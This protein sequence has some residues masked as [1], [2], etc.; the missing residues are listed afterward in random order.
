MLLRRFAWADAEI[1]AGNYAEFRA[2]MVADNLAGLEGLQVGLV[3]FGTIGRA[4]AQ[5]FARM[6]AKRLLLRS[7]AARRLGGSAI[8]AS[9]C[10]STN[11][12]RPPMWC[13][14]TCRCCRRRRA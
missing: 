13:R 9:R 1:K 6:G 10:R 14:C 11:C 5:A 2:R 3:G 8:G 12:W 4:V 7:G